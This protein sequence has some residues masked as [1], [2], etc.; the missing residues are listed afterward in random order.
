MYTENLCQLRISYLPEAEQREYAQAREK[1]LADLAAA[2]DRL[3]QV[4]RDV[5]AMT[6][7]IKQI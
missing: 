5:E 4:R 3:A 2:R 7:G 1:A 6:L